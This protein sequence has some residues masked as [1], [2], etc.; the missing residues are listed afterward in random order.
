M[1][2]QILRNIENEVYI[3]KAETILGMC[4]IGEIK[5]DC[6][7][8]NYEPLLTKEEQE[9]NKKIFDMARK[10]EN[11]DWENFI[12]LIKGQDI[13]DFYDLKKMHPDIEEEKLYMKWFDGSGIRSWWK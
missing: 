8:G 2:I 7:T 13:Q 5:K 11:D 9:N 12:S 4:N 1:T 6:T 10:L 3:K